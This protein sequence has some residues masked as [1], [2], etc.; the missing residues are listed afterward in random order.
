[1]K[2]LPLKYLAVALVFLVISVVAP[3]LIAPSTSPDGGADEAP[4]GGLAHPG[5]PGITGPETPGDNETGG[6]SGG[7]TGASDQGGDKDTTPADPDPEP[8]PE[9][10]PEPPPVPHA[11]EGTEPSKMLASSDIMAGGEIV[12][13]YQSP[14]RI[15]FP[16]GDG[17]PLIE[18]VTTF[19]GNN[20]RDAPSYGFA[21]ISEGKF[22]EKWTRSTGSLTA[23]DGAVWTGHGWSG[24]PL[25]VKWPK[26]TRAI[27]NMHAWA[28]EREELVE[29]IY[30]AMDGNVY[31]AEL[32]TGT[33]TRDRL[34]I[35]YTFKGAGAVD[36]RG[37]PLLYVGAGYTSSKGYARIFII[38]LVDGSV[39]HTFGVGDRFAPRNW[40]A[41]DASPLVDA[42]NDKLIYPSE[43][44]VLYI[45][46]LN[47]EFDPAAGTMRIEPSPPVMWRFKGIRSNKGGGFWLGMESSPAIWG[48]Y[49]YQADNGGHF[50]CL[51][52]NTLEPVWAQ[53]VLD[54]TN[55]T[56]VLEIEDGRPYVYISTGF[57]GGWRAP[58]GGTAPVPVWKF[59]A[60]T[61]EVVWRTD[62]DCY[63]TA[64]VSGGVQGTI[65]V[66]KQSLSH[67]IFVPV[68]RTPTRSAGVLAA[69]DKAAGEVVW[70]FQ[71]TV[72]SWSSPVCVYDPDGKGYI[73][74]A[75]AAGNIY[76]IDGLTGELLDSAK[77]GGTI[78]ASPA[79]FDNTVVLGTRSSLI[80]GLRLT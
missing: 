63:T 40:T 55:N 13:S 34:N 35:G 11:I 45:I 27:M 33:A 18:G 48:G 8:E 28:K 47:S 67:L 56:P 12:E 52:L 42:E 39:L 14:Q 19:R 75:D 77:L 64:G 36:P 43:N 16:H 73:V 44:G 1:M 23:P 5:Q 29:V 69:L 10:E 61:G 54:D 30:P 6:L 21:T 15:G 20:F 17:Y 22:G 79:V 9:P 2:K 70:E 25:I 50:I 68:A 60:V 41:A 4:S 37:Y 38:S 74:Y 72:Y 32:E 71:T 65:A 53:D 62:Y 59:D 78:E 51:D 57:H 26:E 76:L 7:E 66:G 31:F 46:D 3:A 80:W 49:L 24:Q 58:G